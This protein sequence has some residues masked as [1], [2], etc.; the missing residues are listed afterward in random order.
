MEEK[1]NAK[2]F[3]NPFKDMD[4][5]KKKVV[6]GAG[7]FA[8]VLLS[9][10][11]YYFNVKIESQ[12]KTNVQ[13]EK[14]PVNVVERDVSKERWTTEESKKIAELQENQKR[15]EEALRKSEEEKKPC[16]NNKQIILIIFLL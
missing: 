2:T 8:I 5:E 16:N 15:L 13:T 12:K 7:L 10:L 14:P 9:G 4:E 6:I 3:K 11:A 1:E